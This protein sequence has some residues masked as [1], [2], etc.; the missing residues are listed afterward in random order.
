MLL[1]LMLALLAA[2]RFTFH[3]DVYENHYPN[4]MQLDDTLA[5]L[6]QERD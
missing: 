5:K 4:H 2:L 3:G 1:V 6:D